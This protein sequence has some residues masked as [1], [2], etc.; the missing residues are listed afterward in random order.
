MASDSIKHLWTPWRMEYVRRLHKGDD[1]GQCVFCELA[2]A[3]EN[4]ETLVL[5]K[6]DDVFVVMNRFPY[7]NG[8]LMVLPRA[9]FGNIAD[10]PAAT[11]DSIM[12]WA[13]ACCVVLQKE[14][15]AQGFNVGL[16]LGAAAGAGIAGHMHMHIVPRWSGDTN[17]MPILAEVKCIPDHLTNTFQRLHQP[18]KEGIKK[19]I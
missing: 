10:V 15:S 5:H 7:N 17:F 1:H 6:N 14:L 2:G 11:L 13:R 19:L 9:H 4:P 18:I 12:R 3:E 8:H 16:N